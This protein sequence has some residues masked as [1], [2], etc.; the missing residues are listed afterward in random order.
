MRHIKRLNDVKLLSLSSKSTFKIIEKFGVSNENMESPMKILSLKENLWSPI[1]LFGS[2]MKILGSATKIWG[3]N[4]MLGVSYDNRG[5]SNKNFWL[6]NEM[7][8][9]FKAERREYVRVSQLQKQLL[10]FHKYIEFL[11]FMNLFADFFKFFKCRL[12]NKNS[13]K[14][15]ENVC[16][17]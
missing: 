8:G 11:V 6:S 1:N 5:V 7:V 10:L 9:F 16:E 15:T 4:K 17:Q 2:P 14:S 12:F 13:R 3:L